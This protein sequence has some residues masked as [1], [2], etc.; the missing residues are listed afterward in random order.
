[1]KVLGL[2]FSGIPLGLFSQNSYSA[3]SILPVTNQVII[4]EIMADPNPCVGL[5]DAEYIELF[6][7]GDVA[8]PLENWKLAFGTKEKALAAVT[9]Q[10]GEYLIICEGGKEGAFQPYGQV[11][12]MQK[13][14]AIINTGQTLTLKSS[15][16]E[17]IHTVTF[18]PNWYKTHQK[19]QGG[20]SL[21]IIDPDNPCGYSENWSESDDSDGGTPGSEN[22]V[23]DIN[24]DMQSPCLLR[25]T[26]PSDSSVLLI[27]NERMDSS[28]LNFSG[29]YSVSN[30]ILHPVAV[31]PVGPDYSEILLFFNQPFEPLKE[32]TVTVMNSLRDC[33]GNLFCNNAATRFAIPQIPACFDLVINEI[34]PDP[35]PGDAEFIEIYNRSQKVLDMADFTIG[36]ADPQ[37]HELKYTCPLRN[38]SFLLF[39]GDYV[40]ITNLANNLPNKCFSKYQQ[41]IIEHPGIFVLP[42]EEGIIVLTDSLSQII[43]EFRY[44]ESMHAQLLTNSKGISL[45]RVNPDLPTNYPGNWHSASTA[46]GYSTPG[47]KNSQALPPELLPAEIILQPEVFSPDYDGIDDYTTLH[48]QLN[49]PGWIATIMIFDIGGNKIRDLAS[50]SMLGTEEDFLWDGT[51]N[52]GRPAQLGIYLFYIEIF[53]SKGQVKKIKKVVTLTKRI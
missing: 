28:Y 9:L 6:N 29:L 49:E 45:E 30:G 39:P 1:M 47:Q 13:M 31:D 53:N 36:L 17:V 12:P 21:E 52:D 14:P 35:F 34:L 37:T 5:P 3:P 16:G 48:F 11:L 23:S 32:Y 20:W 50:N 27:F 22:S 43:D 44:N 8:I 19:S 40:V 7:R 25:A 38:H 24:P 4:S 10:A 33:S 26:L 41:S 51:L 15:S 2:F 18:S 42:N 46:S